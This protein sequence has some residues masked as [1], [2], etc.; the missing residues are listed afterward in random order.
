MM[1]ALS[2]LVTPAPEAAASAK[3]GKAGKAGKGGEA[4]AK[5]GFANELKGLDG[6]QGRGKGS[7]RGAETKAALKADAETTTETAPVAA[8]LVEEGA[9]ADL[10][11]FAALK[12]GLQTTVEAAQARTAAKQTE[13]KADEVPV[14]TGARTKEPKTVAVGRAKANAV[15]DFSGL[16]KETADKTKIDTAKLAA[17]VRKIE[18][19]AGNA[20]EETAASDDAD[21]ATT[22]VADDKPE[23]RTETLSDVLGLLVAGGASARTDSKPAGATTARNSDVADVGRKAK[24]DT[25]ADVA[26][27]GDGAGE[28]EAIA[29]DAPQ[30]RLFRLT[31]GEGRGQSV[32]LKIANDSSGRIDVE[33]RSPTSGQAETVNVVEARRYLGF[34]APSNSSSLTAALAGNDEWVSAMHPS[35]RLA[36]EAQQSSTGQVVNTLK[37][38]LNPASL[39]SVTAMLRLSGDQLNV[40]LTV[41]TAT[42]YRELRE[43]SSAMLDALR[44][45]GFSVDQVTVSMAPASSTQDGGDAGS[46]FSQQQQQQQNMQQA[47]GEGGRNGDQGARQNARGGSDGQP[48]IAA[49]RI[50]EGEQNSSV[51]RGAGGSRPDHVYI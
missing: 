38:E 18:A 46:R 17:V 15:A 22:S 51:A 39:G 40:H 29:T 41:H 50:D 21:T 34:N 37:L 16:G 14:E 5:D 28:G 1:N 10:R 27:T 20:T 23:A 26:G 48:G 47:A 2:Q 24:T 43:D 6:E 7:A 11:S 4:S 9:V 49:G 13:D 36:N 31:R 8:M 25:A 45:Q 30:D 42:A 12:A 3:S 35:A 32:D 19:T 33:A 44:S